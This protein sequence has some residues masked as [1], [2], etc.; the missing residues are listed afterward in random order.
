MSQTIKLKKGFDINLAGKAAK[1]VSDAPKPE[2]FAIKP[3]DFPSIT[4][5]KL[6]VEQGDKVK[7][8]TPLLYDKMADN[9]LYCSPVS[10]EIAEINRGDKRKLLEIRILADTENQYETFEKFSSS[11]L[12]GLS[13]EDAINQ[14]LKSGVWANIIQ[15]PYGI[16]ANPEDKPKAIFI[17]AFD[18]H[19]LSPDYNFIYKDQ[20]EAFQTGLNILKK[21]TTGKVHLNISAD[22]EVAR[23]FS[24]AEGVQINQFSGKH[25]AGNVGVQIHHLDPINKSDVAWTVKPYG[26]IQIG[27]LFL[28]GKYDA[29]KIVALT[30]S[31]VKEPKYYKTFTGASIK[32]IIKDNIKEGHVRYITGNPLTGEKISDTGYL[33]FY[34]EQITVVP[35]GD[36]EEL[37]GWIKPTTSKL[38]FYRAIGLLSFLNKKKEYVLNT[39]TNGEER[40]FVLTGRFEEVLPMDILPMYLFKAIMAEDF[41]E[42]EALG[43]FELVEEDVALCEFIDTSKHELQM[44][45][46]K[47]INL[48]ING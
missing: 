17:S 31:E 46:R 11:D 39:N 2:T 34:D 24:Q 47:G 38:S 22:N 43:I 15:R 8:G 10:G 32:N 18:T 45:L 3:T 28:E 29:S 40:A 35:E 23:M 13:K 9:I 21:L 6:L 16:V 33:G 19:P 44:I 26:V 42:M 5:P 48:M 25:P 27:K 14:M 37:L 1:V 20:D 4:R 36:F 7:A 41:D 30:G 12:K